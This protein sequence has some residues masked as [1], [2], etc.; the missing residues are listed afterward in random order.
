MLE[1]F[2]AQPSQSDIETYAR[3][4]QWN[5]KIFEN[6]ELTKIDV[7]FFT[8]PK[9][10]Y[11]QFSNRAKIEYRLGQGGGLFGKNCVVIQCSR[12]ACSG[13]ILVFGQN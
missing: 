3:S 10:L 8:L 7:N 6:T 12:I 9:M 5:G 2:G 13:R 11:K 1:Q 4:K